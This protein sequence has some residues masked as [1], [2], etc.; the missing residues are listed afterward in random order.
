MLHIHNG[1]CSANVLKESGMSG[2]HLA[3]RD[4]LMAGPTP[5]GL[6]GEGWRSM[7][8]RFLAQD[9]E[10]D[11]EKCMKSLVEEE[12]AL[13]RF[14]RH[15]EVVLW[16][17]HD[18]FC[19]INL[20]Y[21]LNWLAIKQR[22]ETKL[23]LVC[24]GEFPGIEDFRGLGQ[25]EPAEMASLFDKRVEVSDP[26]LELARRAWLAYCSPSPESI[27]ELSSEETSLLPFLGPALLRHLSRFPTSSNGLGYI[28]N[29]ALQLIAS[30]H[31]EFKRLF[32]EFVNSNSAYGLGDAQ[33]WNDIKRMGQAREPLVVI[34]GV[35]LNRAFAGN[36]FHDA[37]FE[38]TEKGRDVLSGKSDCIDINGLDMWLGGVHLTEANLWRWDEQN[39]KLVRS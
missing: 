4:V 27:E 38:L 6:S 29:R 9:Y 15:E 33:F 39:Q 18:L 37:S 24:I 2:E 16:F 21:L 19:Q 8:A 35:D 20:I 22:G 14:R 28:E 25:L 7:R 11:V 1:D 5:Q 34:K 32:P 31:A 13:E 3:F 17:E 36:R 23:S 10:L 12:E 30:G 26:L